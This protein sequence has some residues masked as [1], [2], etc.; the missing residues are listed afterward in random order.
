MSRS[1]VILIFFLVIFLF[2]FGTVGYMSIEGW[3][4]FD[5][6]YMTVITLTTTGYQEVHQLSDHGRLF[7]MILLICGMGIVAFS[8]SAIMN[9]VLSIDF[10]KRRI[11]RMKN[12]IAELSGHT[13]VCGFGR[14]GKV[15]CKELHM[16]GVPFVVVEIGD[17][18][19]KQLEDCGY[20]HLQ[21]DAAADE[22]LEEAG[23]MRAKSLVS[24]IDN[25]ADGLYLCLAA[26]SLSEKLRIVVRASDERAKKRIEKAGA[27][28]VI[29]PI[30]MSGKRIAE[31]IINPAVE[32]FL[33]VAGAYFEKGEGIQLT[34]I[35]VN[36][37]SSLVDKNVEDISEIVTDLV[38]V[39]IRRKNGDFVFFPKEEHK[40][41]VGDT[42]VSIATEKGYLQTK[43]HF[44]IND[45]L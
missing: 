17:E 45:F 31:S 12:K 25:D 14:I 11:Q 44:D 20:L 7:T 1:H 39:A 9:F 28:K 10:E 34:D 41:Q 23:I 35:V 30:I 19:V 22:V 24:M 32:D 5:S 38:I 43:E 13:I 18:Q 42:L 27:N 6:F 21:G 33:D 36:D 37:D 29:L 15:I 4:S 3:N 2:L 16:K 40:F 26:R 8:V